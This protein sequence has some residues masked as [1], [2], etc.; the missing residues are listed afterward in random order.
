MDYGATAY[1][2]APKTRLQKLDTFKKACL[3]VVGGFFQDNT[4]TCPVG[5][6]HNSNLRKKKNMDDR[7][8]GSEERI[9]EHTSTAKFNQMEK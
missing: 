7:K 9:A 2:N 6:K 8:R 3:R 4:C 1:G 5:S